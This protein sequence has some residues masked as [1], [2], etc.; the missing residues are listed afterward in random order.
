MYQ[1]DRGY[2]TNEPIGKAFTSSCLGK[3][4]ILGV[5]LL[6]ALIVAYFTT[7]TEKEML[8]EM[9][10][11]IIECLEDSVEPLNKIILEYRRLDRNDLPF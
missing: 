11:N 4:V 2:R 5:F 9:D 7:P 3:I 1:Q 8:A 6:I 10:D